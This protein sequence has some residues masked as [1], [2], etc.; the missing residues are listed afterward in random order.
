[1]FTG[2]TAGPPR[3]AMRTAIFNLIPSDSQVAWPP[4]LVGVVDVCGVMIDKDYLHN[5]D[6]KFGLYTCIGTKVC[7]FVG[8][9]CSSL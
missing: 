7:V 3:P 5:L 1:M 6:L 4:L 8:D 2:M 9:E